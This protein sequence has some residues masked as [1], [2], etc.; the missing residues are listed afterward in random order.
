MSVYRDFDQETLNREYRIRESIPLD[1]FEAVIARYGE[2]SAQMRDSLDARLDLR[3]G[4]SPEEVMDIFP[5][6]DG[7]PVLVYIHGGYWRMLSQKESS[8]MAET[9]TNAGVAVAA[10]N[11]GLAPATTLDEI[12]RQCRAAIAWLHANAAGF[13]GDPGRI[14]IAGHSAGGHL[15]GMLLAGG[16]HGEFGVPEDVISSACA[17]SGLH[18]LEP[19]R[20]SEINEWLDLD[21]AAVARNSPIRHLPAHGC[22]LIVSYGGSETSEFKRQTDEYAAAWRANGFP[23]RNVEMDACNHFDLPL[24][25]CDADSALTRAVFDQIGL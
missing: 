20:L 23:C 17:L 3:F 25:W 6:G 1:E 9:F 21:D 7:A 18:E 16:W 8:F 24:A 2:V 13:G 11:Y 12:V 22:P 14:H 19:I 10:V 4:P 15:V 5:T